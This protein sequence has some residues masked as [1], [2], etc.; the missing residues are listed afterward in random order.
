MQPI[1]NDYLNEKDDPEFNDS[2]KDSLKKAGYDFPE[3]EEELDYLIEKFNKTNVVVP[4]EL[5]DP[6]AILKQGMLSVKT[7]FNSSTDQEVDIN[8]AQA[9]REGG[10]IDDEVKNQMNMDRKAAENGRRNKETE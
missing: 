7:D 9:A 2:L 10:T 6:I 4:D 8:L 5:D 1:Y 3:T